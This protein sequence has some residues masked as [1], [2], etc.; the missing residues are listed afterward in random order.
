MSYT[1]L[2]IRINK[3]AVEHGFWESERNLGEMLMLA[4]SELSEALEE[5]RDGNP[6]LWYRHASDCRSSTGQTFTV[7]SGCCNAKPEGAAVE[8][9]DCLIRCLDTLH[10]YWQENFD[11]WIDAER[12][13]LQHY[14]LVSGKENFGDKLFII[15][16]E[17]TASYKHT[18][19]LCRVVVYCEYLIE[20]F[21]F[22]VEKLLLEKMK[23]NDS[24]PYKH[25]KAY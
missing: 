3:T 13:W 6:P 15:V 21:G 14:S 25:G 7:L 11:E 4:V 18:Q 22:E 12:T 10:H 5:H 19:R 23:Y 17:L 2:A 9:A 8:I 16:T 24:R 20:Q 1:D